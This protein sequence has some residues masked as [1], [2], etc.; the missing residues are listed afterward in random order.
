MRL[1]HLLS[2]EIR[3][4]ASGQALYFVGSKDQKLFRCGGETKTADY[5]LPITSQLSKWHGPLA[6]LVRAFL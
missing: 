4:N 3:A 1:D 2:M 5:C 6:Q